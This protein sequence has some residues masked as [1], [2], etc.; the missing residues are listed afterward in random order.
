MAAS[1][2]LGV[3]G[4]SVVV[5]LHATGNENDHFSVAIPGGASSVVSVFGEATVQ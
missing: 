4:F 1:E 5:L 3:A 2:A